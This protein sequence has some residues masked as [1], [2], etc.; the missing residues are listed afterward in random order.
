MLLSIIIPTK[1]R[2]YT[3]LYAIESAISIGIDDIEIIVQDCSETNILASE[4]K[5]KFGNDKRIKYQHDSTSP[6]MTQNWNNAFARSTGEYLCAIGDDDVVLPNIYNLTIW[7]KEKRILAVVQEKFVMYFW[8]D[9]LPKKF[10]ATINI[11]KSICGEITI[12]RD[13]KYEIKKYSTLESHLKYI[14]LPQAYHCIFSREILVELSKQTGRFLDGT[15]ID[16]YSS[17]AFSKII[18][19]YAKVKFPFTIRGAC[20]GSNSQRITTKNMNEHFKEY[21][22]IIFPKLLPKGNDMFT[23]IA[24]SFIK[25]CINTNQIKLIENINLPML[26][27]NIV[28]WNKS[29]FMICNLKLF[30]NVK[31][32]RTRTKFYTYLFKSTFHSMTTKIKSIL[33]PKKLVKDNLNIM[34]IHSISNISYAIEYLK[35]KDKVYYM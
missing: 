20:Y 23:T 9:Y 26:Y 10:G 16:V 18:N 32:W 4:V 25:A 19:I 35:K 13:L 24:E 7:A 21:E 12:E 15:S 31:S 17:I 29:K 34:Q 27:G 30:Q 3:A 1:N 11:P 33:L 5:E 2:N 28:L 22:E 14:Y 8:P 6:S